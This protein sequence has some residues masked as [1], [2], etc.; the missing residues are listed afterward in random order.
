MIMRLLKK[1]GS[2][3][4]TISFLDY[5]LLGDKECA[6][7]SCSCFVLFAQRKDFFSAGVQFT[8]RKKI[9]G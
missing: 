5:F 7:G 3:G 2:D 9:D 4:F 1:T 6:F 8:W